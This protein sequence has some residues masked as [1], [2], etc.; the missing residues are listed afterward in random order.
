MRI[1]NIHIRQHIQTSYLQPDV[2][3]RVLIKDEITPND[4]QVEPGWGDVHHHGGPRGDKGR[5]T[6]AGGQVTTPGAASRPEVGILIAEITQCKAVVDIKQM[7]LK[8]AEC[9]GG[10]RCTCSEE[11]RMR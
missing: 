3:Q 2:G 5:F 11:E 7:D 4:E 1:A 6:L 10:G 8:W 9:S